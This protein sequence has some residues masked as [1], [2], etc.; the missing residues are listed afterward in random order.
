MTFRRYHIA[1]APAPSRRPWTRVNVHRDLSRCLN[2]GTCI[3][4]CLYGVHDRRDTDGRFMEEP[5]DHLCRVCFRCVAE[6]PVNALS[7]ERNTEF[8]EAGNGLYQPEILRTLANEAEAGRIPVTGACYRGPFG[9]QGFDGMWTDMSEIVRP[10]RDG[11]HGREYISTTVDIGARPTYLDGGIR[12]YG[13]DP[14]TGK[15]VH[16]N[17]LVGP[18]PDGGKTVPRD[19][20]FYINGANSDVLVSEGSSPRSSGPRRRSRRMP[21]S[22]PNHGLPLPRSLPTESLCG[23]RTAKSRASREPRALKRRTTRN[24]ERTSGPSERRSRTE[25]CPSAFRSPR[26]GGRPPTSPSMRERT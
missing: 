12:L 24:M 18:F 7:L 5:E 15:I 21:S 3:D 20:S 6:C 19:V 22:P 2:C 17:N 9:G 14:M 26:T 25:S 4:S 13:L 1:A 8:L 23:S 11:I 16:Q 10:T